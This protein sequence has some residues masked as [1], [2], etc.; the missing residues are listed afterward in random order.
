MARRIRFIAS[1]TAAIAAVGLAAASAQS[2]APSPPAGMPARSFATG[3]PAAEAMSA[4][5][6]APER[7]LSTAATEQALAER[8]AVASLSTA[9]PAAQGSWKQYGNAPELDNVK[10]YTPIDATQTDSGRVQDFAYDAAHHRLYA[11]V[12]GGGVWLTTN[13]GGSWRS[14]TDGLP[15]TTAGSVGYSTAHGGTVIDGTGDSGYSFSGLGVWRSFDNGATWHKAT[16]V[17]DGLITFRIAVDPTNPSVIYAAT[18]RGLYRSTDDAATFVNVRLPTGKTAPTG[19]DCAGDTTHFQCVFE[20]YVSDVVV[21]P[22]DADG[23]NHGGEVLAA[24]GWY[25]GDHATS[26]GWNN[27]PNNGIYASPTGNPGTFVDTHADQHGFIHPRGHTGFIRLGIARGPAQNHDIVFAMVEDAQKVDGNL[28]GVDPVPGVPAVCGVAAC[29]TTT[30]GGIYVTSD[31]GGAWTVKEPAPETLANCFVTGTDQCLALAAP[32]PLGGNYGPGVQSW[33]NNWIAVDPTVQDVSGKPTRIFFGVEEPWM[34]DD[35]LGATFNPK[36]IGRYFGNGFCPYLAAGPIAVNN[37]PACPLI[38]NAPTTTHPDQHGQILVP[39]GSGG[40]TL[41]VGNDGGV[42]SQHVGP[43]GTFDNAHWGAGNNVGLSTLLPYMAVI[44]K[45]GTAYA[46]LQDN[47][48]IKVLPD[49]RT[50]QVY[51]GDGFNSAVDP[52]NSKIAYEEYTF[53]QVHVTTDGG[54][55]WREIVAQDTSAQFNAPIAMDPTNANHLVT[56]GESIV[57]TTSGPNTTEP[58]AAPKPTDNATV[59]DTGTSSNGS[60]NSVTAFGVSGSA[61]YAGFCG[62]CYIP[63]VVTPGFESGLATNVGGSKPPKSKSSDGWH[64][65]KAKGLPQR[66]ISKIAVDPADPKTVY[67]AMGNYDPS[68][69]YR[70]PG[71]FGDPTNKLGRTGIYKSVDA[72]QTFTDIS[73]NLPNSTTNWVDLRGGQLIA[74][75]NVGVFISTDLNGGHWSLLGPAGFRAA[76]PVSSQQHFGLAPE[77]DVTTAG[78]LPAGGLPVVPVMSAQ[79]MP[80]NHDKL[81]AATYGRSL[82]TYAFPKGTFVPHPSSQQHHSGLAATGGQLLWPSAGLL[83]I[84]LAL[85][86][87]RRART[88]RTVAA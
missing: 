25:R 36:S 44:A 76:T 19:P 45:D 83:T 84:V 55:T 33:Y 61:V 72:G 1:T 13:S 66:W 88:R 64:K 48:E 20:N 26:T 42:Y 59:F 62:A 40:V 77:V 54:H 78:T 17:P 60:P 85:T 47:G 50:I 10:G 58:G 41:F 32:S 5:L 23:P 79:V 28:P 16:G 27:A 81:F 8:A 65:A 71:S 11:A 87:R 63:S 70:P 34:V 67:V 9:V 7:H 29:Y 18:S 2:T 49:G 51:G 69:D 21:R 75:T 82:W 30:L 68:I 57:E 24:V 12:G 43:G 46:G 6:R 39:D 37:P 80:G 14:I 31:F 22:G 73:G 35:P 86:L 53:D 56:G 52:N 15:A 38:P 74:A 4:A 3:G